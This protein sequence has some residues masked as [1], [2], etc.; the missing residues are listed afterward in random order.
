MDIKFRFLAGAND[1]LG[2]A[3]RALES[4]P[5]EAV[6]SST[7]RRGEPHAKRVRDGNVV[8]VVFAALAVEGFLNELAGIDFSSGEQQPSLVNLNDRLKSLQRVLTLAQDSRIQPVGIL[9]LA[10]R[11]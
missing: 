4:I 7:P 10:T 1:L 6:L 5:A 9:Q 3:K 8:A 11:F 2:I